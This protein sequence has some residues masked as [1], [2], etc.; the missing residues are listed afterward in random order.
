MI[1]KI[2]MSLFYSMGILVFSLL[3]LMLWWS[4]RLA[5]TSKNRHLNFVVLATC[6]LKVLPD[7]IY[8]D[9]NQISATLGII[10]SLSFR[11]FW[12]LEDWH[13]QWKTCVGYGAMTYAHYRIYIHSHRHQHLYGNWWATCCLHS[14]MTTWL[15]P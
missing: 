8:Q 14:P 15:L 11:K 5:C 4:L 13:G 6:N 10:M 2:W 7:I 1:S 9:H 3:V 12:I